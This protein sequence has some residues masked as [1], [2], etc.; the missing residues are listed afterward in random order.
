MDEREKAIIKDIIKDLDKEIFKIK[1]SFVLL[2]IIHISLIIILGFII[3][4]ANMFFKI[5]NM[6]LVAYNGYCVIRII[7]IL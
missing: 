4:P 7:K 3:E 5:F 1:V 6:V 2:I